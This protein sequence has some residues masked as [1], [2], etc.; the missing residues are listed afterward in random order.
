MSTSISVRTC[1]SLAG[2]AVAL[3]QAMTPEFKAYQ[4]Q[5]LAN[6][7]ALSS[8]L[9][10]QGYKIVTGRCHHGEWLTH[11]TINIYNQDKKGRD[12]S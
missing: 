11:E 5:V 12:S 2:V 1:L 10:D 8:G 6:C 7:K 9:I 4:T 3:K